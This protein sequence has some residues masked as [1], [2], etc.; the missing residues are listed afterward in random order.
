MIGPPKKAKILP[1]SPVEVSA[2]RRILSGGWISLSPVEEVSAAIRCWQVWARLALD[3]T[4]AQYRRTALG[5]VWITIAQAAWIFGIYQLRPV[6]RGGGDDGYLIHLTAGLILFG[7]VG[8]WLSAS[9]GTFTRASAHMM[10]HNISPA[11]FAV[12]GTAR[13]FVNLAHTAPVFFVVAIL[14][15]HPIS[16]VAFWALPALVAI[17]I[18]TLGA[19]LALGSLGVRFRDMSFAGASVSSL[20]FILTPIIWLPT[21]EQK[22][23]PLIY[24]NPFY[25]AIESVRAPLIGGEPAF[26]SLAITFVM[27]AFMLS[28]GMVVYGAMRRQLSIWL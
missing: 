3:D 18:A 1:Q 5:P 24:F 25:H 8:S 23:N 6:F 4:W 7:I 10:N 14:I 17:A 27:A 15:N 20:V 28:A 16:L 13:E 26:A 19:N 2:S 9:P 22:D 21:A 11:I 12:R